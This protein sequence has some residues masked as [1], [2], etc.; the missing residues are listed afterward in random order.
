MFW[1]LSFYYFEV[2]R[3]VFV[4]RVLYC[5]I[6]RSIPLV[7]LFLCYFSCCWVFRVRF[8][9]IWIEWYIYFAHTY[10]LVVFYCVYIHRYCVFCWDMLYTIPYPLEFVFIYF[11]YLLCLVRIK[12]WLFNLL[13]SCCSLIS[14]SN[15]ITILYFDMY[16]CVYIL[17]YDN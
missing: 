13:L 9:S 2:F 15:Y 8:V 11:I 17:G 1:L 5:L 6:L 14:S 4:N 10:E 12:F 16:R 7:L 3:R